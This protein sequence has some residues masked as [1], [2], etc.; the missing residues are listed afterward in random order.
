MLLQHV[1]IAKFTIL[2]LK[3]W[4]KFIRKFLG[5]ELKVKGNS[6]NVLFNEIMEHLIAEDKILVVALDDF[7]F[8]KKELNNTLFNLLRAHETFHDVPVGV[9]TITSKTTDIMLKPI[10]TVYLPV[11][12]FFDSYNQEQIFDI[13]KMRCKVGFYQGVI[14]DDLINRI[15][16]MTYM[17]GNL[18]Y[19][20]DLLKTLGEIA[21]SEGSNKILFKHLNKLELNIFIFLISCITFIIIDNI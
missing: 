6:K 10:S 1:L 12:I 15:A 13:L 3:L 8:L 2:N 20:I 18:R 7:D 17:K 5:H 19:D 16:E 14:K 21:E 9:Y 11:E 4:L